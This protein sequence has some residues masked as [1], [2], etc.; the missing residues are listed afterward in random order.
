MIEKDKK[1]IEENKFV[2]AL[3]Y[4]WILCLVPLF[5]KRQSKFAQFHAQQGLVLFIIEIFGWLIFPLPIIG[6]IIFI[7]VILYSIIGA[8]KALAG[9][10]WSMPFLNKLVRKINI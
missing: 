5:F 1:D 4:V 6:Q 9:K 8:Q 7:M 10:Y 2:A 3:S